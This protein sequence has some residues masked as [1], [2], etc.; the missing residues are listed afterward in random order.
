[1]W[2]TS[3]LGLVITLTKPSWTV[4][5]EAQLKSLHHP[6][7]HLATTTDVSK[8]TRSLVFKLT[9]GVKFILAG[10]RCLDQMNLELMH[11]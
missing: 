7:L 9:I 10:A 11:A 8:A 2:K 5:Q 4:G 3:A 1:M 6:I